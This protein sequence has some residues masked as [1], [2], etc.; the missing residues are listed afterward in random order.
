MAD[1]T[2]PRDI[3]SWYAAVVLEVAE[4]L[5]RRI[6]IEGLYRDDEDGHFIPAEDVT[7]AR[8]QF[9]DGSTGNRAR[10]AGDLAAASAMWS[11]CAP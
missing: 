2:I 9:E 7:W 6:G 10:V 4:R 5:P 1:A 3:D 11:M 8:P